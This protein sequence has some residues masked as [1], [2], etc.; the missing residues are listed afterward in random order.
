MTNETLDQ[1][2]LDE[3]DQIIETV[4]YDF[5]P[6]AEL[7]RRR[8]VQILGAGLLICAV[9]DSATAQPAPGGGGG[10]NRGRGGRGGGGGFAGSGSTTLDARLHI[11][12]DGT[13]TVMSGKVEGGQ[14]ARAE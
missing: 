1:I 6:P 8:F 14:G 3:Q 13:I 4:G 2:G 9:A 7:S 5:A 11:A 12:K 10:G